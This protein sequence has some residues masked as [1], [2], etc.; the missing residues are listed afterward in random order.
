LLGF[1]PSFLSINVESPRERGSFLRPSLL[2]SQPES[3]LYKSLLNALDLRP[4]HKT[5]FLNKSLYLWSKLALPEYIL[6]VLGDRMEMAHSVEGRVPFLD[7]KL[8]ELANSLPVSLKIKGGMEKYVLRQS[9]KG[10]LTDTVYKRHKHP[11]LAPPGT[12]SEANALF[13]YFS[14][15]IH[16]ESFATQPFWDHKAVKKLIED[17][18]VT[19]SE[20]CLK[21]DQ[22]IN[23]MV[24]TTLLAKIFKVS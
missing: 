4:I 5:H 21:I 1:V 23:M 3:T 12:R 20:Q 18:P 6:T 2:E 14:D 17:I 7:H 19:A 11:F 24:S 13:D 9:M 10:L 15:I 16:S 8:V 22:L